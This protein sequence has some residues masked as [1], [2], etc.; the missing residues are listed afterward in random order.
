[1][2]ED[3]QRCIGL[4]FRRKGK[5]LMSE[6]EFVY[7]VSMDLHWFTPKEA[8][9]LLDIAVRSGRLK[10]SQGMLSPTFK[11]HDYDLAVDYRP[12]E[13]ILKIQTK[14]EK[15]ELFMELVGRIAE[16]AKLP[17]KE[18]VARANKTR[19]NIP[20]DIEVAAL[21]VGRSLDVEIDEQIAEVEKEILSR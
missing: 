20:V 16:K 14:K 7:T 2:T 17:K 13:S 4:L 15:K 19:D 12:P 18:I 11:M 21:I 6:R 8:Q 5:E 1:M 3:L 10:L 9:R